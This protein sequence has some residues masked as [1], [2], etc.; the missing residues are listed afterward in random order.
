MGVYVYY[1]LFKGGL[2]DKTKLKEYAKTHNY[3]IVSSY[4]DND[5]TVYISH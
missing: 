5:I 1:N 2:S 3:K 4:S